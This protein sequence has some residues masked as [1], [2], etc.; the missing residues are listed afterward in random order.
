MLNSTLLK[1]QGK[2]NSICIDYKPAISLYSILSLLNRSKGYTEARFNDLTIRSAFQ[3]IYSVSHQRI[4]GYEALARINDQNR[5]RINPSQFFTSLEDEYELVLAD[6]LCRC[7]HLDSFAKIDDP[8]NW[9]FI[10]I[11]PKVATVGRKY[12]TFF[13]ALIEDSGISAN[14]VV[15]EIVE[16]EESELDQLKE[17]VN[18]FRD[19]GCLIAIDDFG[20]GYSNFERVWSLKPDIIK[21]DQSMIQQAST[22]AEIRNLLPGIVSLLHQSGA[23]VLIEGVENRDQAMISLESDA[24]FAQGFFFCRPIANK[25]QVPDNKNIFDH[26]FKRYVDSTQKKSRAN[27]LLID[28]YKKTFLDTIVKIKKEIPLSR[29]CNELFK[30]RSIVRGYLL[31]SDGV[32]MGE[33]VHCPNRVSEKNLKLKPIQSAEKANWVRRHYVQRAFFN[34]NQIQI[35]R[36]Y[37]SITGAHMCMTLSMLFSSP[38]GEQVFCCDIDLD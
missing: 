14:R 11:S 7:L 32:Q 23:L 13:K 15:V 10:N 29:A 30:D 33:T 38:R 36:P 22:I 18:Y 21:L 17:T 37:L 3:P 20:S 35:T 34:P 27:A 8:I 4:V 31:K 16:H 2:P 28:R 19:L 25:D 5:K 1:K 6:R 12:G 9:I 24:D 26:L